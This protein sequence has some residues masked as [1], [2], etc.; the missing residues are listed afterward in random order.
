MK[1][2]RAFVVEIST[3]FIITRAIFNFQNNVYIPISM[4]SIREIIMAIDE[5]CVYSILFTR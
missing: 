1:K 4:K 5:L 2:F 3:L